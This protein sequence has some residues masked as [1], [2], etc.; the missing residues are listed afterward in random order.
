M[1]V[2]NW[3]MRLGNCR[4]RFILSLNHKIFMNRLIVSI[5]PAEL[6]IRLPKRI[7]YY[8]LLWASRGLDTETLL[9]HTLEPNRNVLFQ[10]HLLFVTIF[11]WSH[12]ELF[13]I[14]WCW[15]FWKFPIIAHTSSVKYKKMVAVKEGMQGFSQCI[16]THRQRHTH[17][18]THPP[19]HPHTHTHTHYTK[20]G[21]FL[22]AIIRSTW[23]FYSPIL[24][25]IGAEY[26]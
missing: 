16:Y 25:V 24:P 7:P 19:T 6:S 20:V 26:I 21:V 18:P 13:N 1:P 14:R 9:F 8:Q 10:T 15:H 2:T 5:W 23:I 4:M 11:I 3:K 17:T 12:M 22:I